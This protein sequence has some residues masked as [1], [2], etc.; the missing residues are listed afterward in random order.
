MLPPPMT[1]GALAKKAK[2]G[3]ETRSLYSAREGLLPKPQ[4]TEKGYRSY[5]P[6][7]E[8]RV[9]FIRR[10]KEL[11]FSLDEITDL[12]NRSSGALY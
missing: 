1:I 11:G 12:L 8:Q 6:D 3:V 9:L 7:A 4:R 10:A 5:A 2:V